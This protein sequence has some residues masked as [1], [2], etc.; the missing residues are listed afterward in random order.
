MRREA[1]DK[2]VKPETALHLRHLHFLTNPS[3]RTHIVSVAAP[4]SAK[5]LQIYSEYLPALLQVD[6]AQLETRTK[7]WFPKCR[8]LGIPLS[9]G[10][11]E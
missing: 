1:G 9:V 4:L 5:A 10:D 2:W 6:S 3:S 7:P 11:K 8:P